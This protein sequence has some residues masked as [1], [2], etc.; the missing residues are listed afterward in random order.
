[1]ALRGRR[2]PTSAEARAR[3][4]EHLDS[5]ER[6]LAETGVPRSDR[7]GIRDEVEAQACE[8]HLWTTCHSPPR[9][10]V[11][12]VTIYDHLHVD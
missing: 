10:D 1:M 9:V 5:V 6:V 2:S 4:D 11:A 12:A 7:R 3:L 8:I